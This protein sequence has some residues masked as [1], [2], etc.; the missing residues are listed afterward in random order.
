[1]PAEQLAQLPAR[2]DAAKKPAAQA[3]QLEAPAAANMP[4]EQLPHAL[5]VDSPVKLW[6]VPALQLVQVVL[7]EKAW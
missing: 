5:E 4:T 6:A 2:D 3:V 7:P 1:M